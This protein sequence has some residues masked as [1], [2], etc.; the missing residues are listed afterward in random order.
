MFSIIELL[1][2]WDGAGVSEIASELGLAKSTASNHLATLEAHEYVVRDGDTYRIGL[3]FLNHGRYAKNRQQVMEVTPPRLEQLATDTS[4]LIWLVVEEHGRAVYLHKAVGDQAVQTRESV[5][6]RGYMHCIAAG[7]AI[8]AHLPESY[9]RQIIERHGL[10][11]LTEKTI[12]DTNELSDELET[13]RA[14]GVAFNR[15]EE[16]TGVRAIGAPITVNKKVY[17]AVCVTGPAERLK[18]DRFTEDLP[19]LVMGAVNDIELRLEYMKE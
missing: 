18:G 8:L 1:Q 11:K 7:K 15:Q 13:V 9:V 6:S 2:E 16:V 4:E 14:E 19:D 10:P 3:K 5:G 17:G 12:T